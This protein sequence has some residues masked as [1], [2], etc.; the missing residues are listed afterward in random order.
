MAKKK[1]KKLKSKVQIQTRHCRKKVVL[2]ANDN[3]TIVTCCL[4]GEIGVDV[5]S[6][7]VS[8]WATDHP[9]VSENCTVHFR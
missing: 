7:V 5:I 6:R 1:K 8:M 9:R 4:V 2:E 3:Y